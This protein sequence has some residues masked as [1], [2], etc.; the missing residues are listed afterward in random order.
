MRF[1]TRSLLL[2]LTFVV[3]TGLM[4]LVVGATFARWRWQDGTS[5]EAVF[6]DAAGLETGVDVRASGV[7]VGTVS[8]IELKGEDVVV[9]FTVPASLPVTQSTEARIRYANLTGDRYLDLT[10]GRDPGAARL[11][12]GD[13][14]PVQRTLTALDLDT[15]FAGFD[16]LMQALDPDEVNQLT[17]NL[18]AVTQG[19]AGAIQDMLAQV[20][21]FTSHLAAR[22][23][24]IGDVIHNLTRALTA[25]DDHH[26]ELDDLV[27]GL[28]GLM[29]GL[30]QDRRTL[31][32]SLVGINNLAVDTTDLLA[33]VRPDLK[34][35]ID[36]LGAVSK[37]LNGN[38]K[39]IEEVLD[40]YPSTIQRLG[41]GG[42]YGSFFNFFLCSVQVNVT[43]PGAPTITTPR[44]TS[45]ADR[46]KFPEDR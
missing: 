10:P 45:D 15:L 5:Y 37:A 19:Q 8:H 33:K 26:D 31:G 44:Q 32:R 39:S 2:V 41:R 1:K 16:P 38:I 13:T 7:A 34:A 35:N 3:S 46:C 27:V 12:E 21:S 11:G 30:A 14:I 40:L 24:L 42:S 36:Q 23:Q 6:T 17:A 29:S 18:L 43:L 22:D 25:V 20:A 9:T 4:L 28:D